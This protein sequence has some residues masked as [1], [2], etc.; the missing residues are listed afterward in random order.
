[1][2]LRNIYLLG[3]ILSVALI[4][5]AFGS[6][7]YGQGRGGGRPANAGPPSGN[8]GPDRGLGNASSRSDG[9]SDTGLGTAATRSNGRSSDGLDR[10]RLARQNASA[11]SER[12]LNRYNGLSQRLGTTPSEMRAAYHAALL[13][14][15]D[16]PFGKFVAANMIAENLNA[17]FP[18]ITSSAIL[19]GLANG[20]SL[21]RTLKNLGLTGDE[22]EIEEKAAKERIKAGKKNRL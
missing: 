5:G 1:M 17:R 9:R 8:P 18:A 21:G 3:G 16:L 19:A 6:D 14:N 22:A 2:K 11:V 10:A 20:D 12:E 15:P 4:C 13:A 7:A